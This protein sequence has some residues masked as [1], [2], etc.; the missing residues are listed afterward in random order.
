MSNHVHLI[1]SPK[2][3]NVSDV[4]GDFKKFTSKKLVSAIQNNAVE[5]C[6]EWMIKIFKEAGELNSRNANY[7][8]CKQDNE[9]KGDLH[10]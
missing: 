5:S 6:K 3:N 9:P 2:E 1:I 10:S 7:Q 8:F 4:L